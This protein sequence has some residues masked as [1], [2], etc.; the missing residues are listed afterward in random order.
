MKKVLKSKILDENNVIVNEPN[1]E[2][3][4]LVVKEKMKQLDNPNK[5]LMSREETPLGNSWEAWIER[6]CKWY[7]EVTRDSHFI[8]KFEKV[9]LN[10]DYKL[11]F[12]TKPI[13]KTNEKR[14]IYDITIP[15]NYFVFFPLISNLI[16]VPEYLSLKSKVEVCLLAKNDLDKTALIFLSINEFQVKNTEKYRIQSNVFDSYMNNNE[17]LYKANAHYIADGYWIFLNPL[18]VGTNKIYFKIQTT[19]NNSLSNEKTGIYKYKMETELIYNLNVI[20]Q[21]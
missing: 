1:L 15:T 16:R 17:T 14:I 8:M 20:D 9:K 4:D 11:I 19:S 2:Y 10:H 13:I 3:I 21:N 7:S 5:L 6:W 18:P 12:L